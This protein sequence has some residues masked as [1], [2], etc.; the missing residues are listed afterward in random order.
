MTLKDDNDD[1]NKKVSF[2]DL[3]ND[4]INIITSFLLLIEIIYLEN[5]CHLFLNICQRNTYQIMKL[6]TIIYIINI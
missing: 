1:N 4:M 2:L 6:E 5:T 3:P